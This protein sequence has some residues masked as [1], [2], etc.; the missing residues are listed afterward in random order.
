[1]EGTV[2]SKT[3]AEVRAAIDVLTTYYAL[4]PD[5]DINFYPPRYPQGNMDLQP[6]GS[7]S[8]Q[9]ATPEDF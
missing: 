6:I 2:K 5:G 8:S 3:P 4:A 9:L 7:T 1:M